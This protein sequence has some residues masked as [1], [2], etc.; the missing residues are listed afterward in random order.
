MTRRVRYTNVITVSEIHRDLATQLA[1]KDSRLVVKENGLNRQANL[2]LKVAWVRADVGSLC[3]C[4]SR[5]STEENRGLFGGLLLKCA[6][7]TKCAV[8][9]QR[10]V[11]K[12][13]TVGLKCDLSFVELFP[14]SMMSIVDLSDQQV[15]LRGMWAIWFVECFEATE[16][17]GREN[18]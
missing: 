11:I 1:T 10:L 15:S 5:L 2:G 18:T 16:C 9:K 17:F 14:T 3:G 7:T 12:D 13:K 4:F 8:E 6:G